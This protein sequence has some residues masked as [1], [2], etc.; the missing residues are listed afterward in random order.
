MALVAQGDRDAL[1]VLVT[2]HQAKVLGL[3]YRFLGQPELAED[4]AQDVFLRVWQKAARFRP[5][6]R[7][8]TWLYRLTANL[9]W[10]RRRRAMREARARAEVPERGSAAEPAVA[11]DIQERVQRVRRAVANLP[12]RQRLA[13]I[14]HR[15]AGL[16][17]RE[18]AE[19]TGWSGKAVESCLVRAYESLRKSLSDLNPR[20]PG[21]ID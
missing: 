16:S 14:L 21:R 5:E 18:I 12:D 1:S 20:E 11:V 19:V 8:T 4:V 17:H 2:R 9:C 15:Y 6:A 7:F 3:A 13:V 10:D